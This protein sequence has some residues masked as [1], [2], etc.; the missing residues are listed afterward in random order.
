MDIITVEQDKMID[1]LLQG[2][3]ITSI[4][5]KLNI[6]R[7]TVYAWKDLTYVKA[8]LEERREQLKKSA[9]N[10]ITN[11]VCQ[12][13]ENMKEL[14]NTATDARI[15]FQANKYLIDQCL[16]SPKAQSS[17][18]KGNNDNQDKNKDVNE[19]KKDIDDI[20]KLKAI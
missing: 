12:Y 4:A 18:T 5:N 1:L 19:L 14:A 16:G 3:T 2:Q 15:R 17:E 8:E 10:K 13:V 9:Q 7:S 6:A 20:K 11:D